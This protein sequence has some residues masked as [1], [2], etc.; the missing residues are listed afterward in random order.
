MQL[1][2]EKAPPGWD[3]MNMQLIIETDVVQESHTQSRI[4]ESYFGRPS[5]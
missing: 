2:A 3:K 1:L 5:D 4:L